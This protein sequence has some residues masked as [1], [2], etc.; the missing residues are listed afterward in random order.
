MGE[1]EGQEGRKSQADSWPLN[2]GH[3]PEH[4]AEEDRVVA[5]RL[6]LKTLCLS[7]LESGWP[8][9]PMR[10]QGRW[11]S[12]ASQFSW[13]H[14]TIPS[15]GRANGSEDVDRFKLASEQTHRKG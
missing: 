2:E 11:E 13:K 6:S 8:T 10:Q 4:V 14:V 7:S 15:V 9:S 1:G 12:C 5:P 3:F